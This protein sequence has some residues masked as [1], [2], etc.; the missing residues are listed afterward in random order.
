MTISDGNKEEQE[1][2]ADAWARLEKQLRASEQSPLWEQW[3]KQGQQAHAEHQVNGEPAAADAVQAPAQASRMTPA[4]EQLNAVPLG[5]ASIHS[6][7][8]ANKASKSGAARRWIKRN[9]GKTIA[10]C[11]AALITVVIATPSTNE[12]L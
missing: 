4:H 3:E 5:R 10:A 7:E 1:Q 2:T 9:V 12:A 8:T 11:A 6:D